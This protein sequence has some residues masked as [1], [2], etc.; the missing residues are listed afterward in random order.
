[1]APSRGSIC[2]VGEEGNKGE[3]GGTG[4]LG[5]EFYDF[6]RDTVWAGGF[7]GA[8]RVNRVIKCISCYHVGEC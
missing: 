4:R 3:E 8:E 5:E 2:L 7:A 6:V 1:M